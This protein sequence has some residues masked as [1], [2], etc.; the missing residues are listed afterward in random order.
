MEYQTEGGQVRYKG[1]PAEPGQTGEPEETAAIVR[2]LAD[3]ITYQSGEKP[4]TG[5]VRAE[6]LASCAGVDAPERG[7]AV[8]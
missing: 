7:V 6:P 2:D 4:G 1:G 3:L 5:T 8:G